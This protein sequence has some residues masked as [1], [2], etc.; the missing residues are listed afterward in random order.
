M[1]RLT[2][3]HLRIFA[4]V[5]KH[6]SFSKTSVVL[7][8]AQPTISRQISELEGHWGGELFYRTGRGVGLSDI[9]EKAHARVVPILR[10]ID[11]LTDDIRSE[12]GTPTGEVTIAIIPSLTA[13]I[14]PSLIE[15]LRSA[16]PGILVRVL[17]G[18]SE[19]VI[20]WVSDGSAD[21]GLH[22]SYREDPEANDPLA[23]KSRVVLVSPSKGTMHPAEIPFA[24]LSQ[25]E[26]VL[27]MQ[28]NALRIC[29]D[30]LARQQNMKLNVVA[31]AVTFSAQKEISAHC[32]YSFLAE[33]SLPALVHLDERF[34][35]SVVCRPYLL[36]TVIMSTGSHS[37]LTRAS[38]MV[39][40]HLSAVMRQSKIDF[41][42]A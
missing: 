10:D 23:K 5:A 18:F 16:H 42:E 22:S 11:K 9:G 39:A 31:E 34:A 38:R 33:R 13:A 21:I 3:Q 15:N 27:P 1:S 30:L 24:S 12:R 29:V 7:G 8:I 4:C 26:L 17:E 35:A 32:G 41:F 20:R 19:Q 14:L 40:E 37:P 6:R 2:L 36:R 28:P 25:Y